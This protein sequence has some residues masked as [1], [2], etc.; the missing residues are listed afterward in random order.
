M[1]TNPKKTVD[2]FTFTKEIPN[3]K[4]YF[5]YSSPKK[6]FSKFNKSTKRSLCT[7]PPVTKLNKQ[8]KHIIGKTF[9]IFLKVH[10]LVWDFF[11]KQNPFKSDMLNFFFL[12]IFT[13]L[14]WLFGYVEKR[15]VRTAKVNLK[16]Y[17]VPDWPANNCNT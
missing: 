9:D 13:F 16:I 12:E 6:K 8:A 15:L 11:D 4:L 5:L 17:D 1:W 10:S 2:L 3:G 7:F 14:L